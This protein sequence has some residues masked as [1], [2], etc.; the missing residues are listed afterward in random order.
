MKKAAFEHNQYIF[1]FFNLSIGLERLFKLIIV[2]ESLRKN[3]NIGE[4]NFKKNFGHDLTKL[5]ITKDKT[6]GYE[7]VYYPKHPLRKRKSGSKG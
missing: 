1:D 4:Q 6:L 3:K 5:K 2:C 7:V